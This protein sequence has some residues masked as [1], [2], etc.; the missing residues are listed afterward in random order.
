MKTPSYKIRL[1]ECLALILKVIN[2]RRII[3]RRPQSC[4]KTLNSQNSSDDIHCQIIS[5]QTSV[6]MESKPWSSCE[7][8][9]RPSSLLRRLRNLIV[10]PRHGYR[11][12]IPGS[13]PEQQKR[14]PIY[15]PNCERE[16]DWI[17]Q[18]A[19]MLETLRQE[20]EESRMAHIKERNEYIRRVG[21]QEEFRGLAKCSHFFTQHAR[22]YA[23]DPRTGEIIDRLPKDQCGSVRELQEF[24]CLDSYYDVVGKDVLSALI[25]GRIR[26]DVSLL[27][28]VDAW[29]EDS[30]WC[31]F[32]ASQGDTQLCRC[33]MEQKL[34]NE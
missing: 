6:E 34:K 18:L 3:L 33:T 13:Y 19:K 1:F 17:R 25:V 26:R 27:R 30:G 14:L 22:P 21:D 12:L 24:A 23:Y 16:W 31:C 15:M 32:L 28:G 8:E 10:P 20:S 5:K 2:F 11:R 4:K 29:A 9:W 7:L